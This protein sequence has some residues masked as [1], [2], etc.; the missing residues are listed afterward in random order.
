MTCEHCRFWAYYQKSYS[1]GECRRRSPVP[2]LML[3]NNVVERV[4]SGTFWPTTDASQ[5]CGEFEPR[6]EP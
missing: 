5:G 2:V 4:P 1:K 6:S 3:L